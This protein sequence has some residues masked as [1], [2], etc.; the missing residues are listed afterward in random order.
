MKNIEIRNLLHKR[1][2]AQWKV[3]KRLGLHESVFSRRLREELPPKEKQKILATIE[4]LAKED[5]T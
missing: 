2:V 5:N 3:A 1:K 4:E